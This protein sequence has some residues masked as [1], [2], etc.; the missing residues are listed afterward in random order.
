MARYILINALP[1]GL[2]A[3]TVLDTAQRSDI[4]SIAAA[5]GALV[6]LPN[7]PVEAAAAQARSAYSRGASDEMASGIMLGAL[8]LSGSGGG[9]DLFIFKGDGS[10]QKG[11]EFGKWSDLMGVTSELQS[12]RSGL[13]PRI[14]FT[15]PFTVPL[16]GM[17]ATGWPMALASWESILP[18]TGAITV[19]IPPGATID[20]IA[21]IGYGLGVE[22]NPAVDGETFQWSE[23]PPGSVPWVLAAGNGCSLHNSS[24]R[25]LVKTPGV[26]TQ[27]YFVLANSGAT[28]GT[29]GPTGPFV[30][31]QGN[32]VVI[33][34][35]LVNGFSPVP[36][37]WAE[38]SAGSTLLLYQNGIDSGFPVISWAGTVFEQYNGTNSLQ[39]N[40]KN[41]TLADRAAL[42]LAPFAP[43]GLKVGSTYF[44]TDQ[45][46]NG[47]PLWWTGTAWVDAT[48]TVIP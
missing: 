12:E 10:A 19:T 22:C 15:Q 9:G 35:Q 27:T 28:W 20:M 33:C 44:A 7:A 8:G 48:G 37:G 29:G 43:Y 11:S 1:G 32:D 4:P 30:K 41:G 45:G 24:P 5:G 2:K 17:P 3:G 34:S 39:L 16:D 36:D 23:F 26:A 47:A 21:S 46:P 38:S 13:R 31:A 14:R 18:V 42:A 25:A 6:L 40:Q